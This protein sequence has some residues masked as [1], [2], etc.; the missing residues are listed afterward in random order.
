MDIFLYF[1][2]LKGTE[3]QLYVWLIL[4]RNYIFS[5]LSMKPVLPHIILFLCEA[6]RI[7]L[8]D[9]CPLVE[10]TMQM[11]G[12][13]RPQENCFYITFSAHCLGLRSKPYLSCESSWINNSHNF[14]FNSPVLQYLHFVYSPYIHKYFLFC[15][16]SEYYE[17]TVA[18]IPVQK[19]RILRTEVNYLR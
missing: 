18:W 12:A 19:W 11:L 17:Y 16:G 6:G 8:L 5:F 15:C 1:L 3:N 7:Q 9:K 14:T 4:G 2:P 13:G 10:R